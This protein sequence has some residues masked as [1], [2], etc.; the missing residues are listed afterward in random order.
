VTSARRADWVGVALTVILAL[1]G[2]RSYFVVMPRRYPPN[3]ED[4]IFWR[5]QE[6]ETGSNLVFV[7]GDSSPG[8]S[9]WGI[10]HFDL[11]V[12]YHSVPAERVQSA[13]FRALCGSDCRVFCLPEDAQVVLER[14][15][16]QLGAGAVRA[17]FGPGGRVVGVEFAP[18]P[19]GGNPP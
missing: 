10:E 16:A 15:R 17:H 9:V 19:A 6:M 12:T 4:V 2:L 11:D 13:D 18:Q 8:F 3:L 1:L 14:L 5:A 7:E